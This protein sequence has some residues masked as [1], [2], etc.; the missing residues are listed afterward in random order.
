MDIS[1]MILRSDWIAAVLALTMILSAPAASKIATLVAQQ[2]ND[3]GAD[4]PLAQRVKADKSKTPDKAKVV[5]R[6]YDPATKKVLTVYSDGT[7][8][9]EVVKL[10]A[11]IPTARAA[12]VTLAVCP[13][14]G[15]NIATGKKGPSK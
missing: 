6:D 11:T 13:H 9:N 8:S 10:V 5:S 7:R 14:C 3:I 1:R 4:V 2:K 15:K 12:L